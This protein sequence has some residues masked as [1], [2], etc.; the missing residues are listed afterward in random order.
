MVDLQTGRRVTVGRDSKLF[1]PAFSRDGRLVYATRGNGALWAYDWRTGAA[2]P[3]AREPGG[4]EQRERAR[5]A[6][7]ASRRS[8]SPTA[9]RSSSS[10]TA[11]R[12]TART[13]R[14]RRARRPGSRRTARASW[15]SRRTARCAST[16]VRPAQRFRI[17]WRRLGADSPQRREQA[18]PIGVAAAYS[19]PAMSTT[20]APQVARVDETAGL[21]AALGTLGTPRGVPVIV[22][23]GAG[24]LDAA[25]VERLTPIVR[26]ALAPLARALGAVVVDGGTDSG[27]M[28]LMGRTRAESPTTFPLVG[29]A[30]EGAVAA[31]GHDG[32]PLE[33]NHS[34]R[35]ARH[36]GEVR[37]RVDGDRRDRHRD[38][39]GHAVG[40][41]A[42][43]R[44]RRL[45]GPTSRPASRPAGR[46]WWSRGA[47]GRPTPSRPP[48]PAPTATPGPRRS[49]PPVS[50]RSCP[51]GTCL[52]SPGRSGGC[53]AASRRRRRPSRRPRRPTGDYHAWMRNDYGAL[54]D[55]LALT[56]FDRHVL[57]SR[58]LDQILF[59][60]RARPAAPSGCTTRCGWSRSSAA[61]SS[62]PSSASASAGTVGTTAR[63]AAWFVGVTGGDRR[64]DRR[65]LPLRR[66]LAPLPP[67]GRAA[68]GRR[69]AVLRAG[70]AVRRYDTH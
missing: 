8:A 48:S 38:R 49:R 16:A 6:P 5:R 59:A 67:P 2:P 43:R 57:R 41:R 19:R 17:C 29:V 52:R 66:A 68:E 11:A 63:T 25:G 58:W 15:C 33:A 36:R 54:L 61:S 24:T 56:A 70:R 39:P 65:L 18:L 21:D 13:I 35:P 37:R 3:G 47:A 22:L 10:P 42:A 34:L 51:P 9:W 1:T 20:A 62:R 30:P 69:L 55:Q 23:V 32:V 7:P 40:H 46:C 26:D 4:R 12:S 44:R 27:V 14:G 60:D 45:A 50:S 28:Q 31:N 64:G 53:S